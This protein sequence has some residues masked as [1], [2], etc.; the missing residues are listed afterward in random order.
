V[1]QQLRPRLTKNGP[2]ISSRDRPLAYAPYR[3]HRPAISTKVDCQSWRQS[4]VQILLGLQRE[5]L[6]CHTSNITEQLRVP[7]GWAVNGSA[8]SIPM[9]LGVTAAFASTAMST[10]TFGKRRSDESHGDRFPVGLHGCRMPPPKRARSGKAT[11]ILAARSAARTRRKPVDRIPNTIIIN[12]KPK[13]VGSG[14]RKLAAPN[15]QGNHRL[16]MLGPHRGGQ[17][18]IRTS[19]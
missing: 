8:W 14:A 15:S 3:L 9:A 12:G 6:F 18:K 13:E 5:Y 17:K 10:V 11:G 1:A 2:G 7:V 4:T 19:S 16:P